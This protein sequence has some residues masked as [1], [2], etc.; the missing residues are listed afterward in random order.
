MSSS[1]KFMVI[2]NQLNIAKAA[3][4]NDVRI[5]IDIERNGKKSRQKHK[6]TLISDHTLEDLSRLKERIPDGEFILRINPLYDHTKDEIDSGISRG[7]DHIMLPMFRKVES[8]EKTANFINGKASLIPL[9]ETGAALVRLESICKVSGV[10][11]IHLG[12]NDLSIDLSLDFLFEPLIGGLVDLFCHTSNKNGKIYGFGG[13]STIG[14]G[15]IPSET[16][17]KE[18]ARLGS[19]RAILSRLFVKNVLS[20]SDDSKDLSKIFSH[21]LSKIRDIYEQYNQ[22]NRDIC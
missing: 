17:I 22:K 10:E 12:L 8:V 18:H 11:E 2:T 5:M 16:I 13:I 3:Y 1:L 9:V 6:D 21:E 15:T 19:R 20:K 7:A 14:S 4:N